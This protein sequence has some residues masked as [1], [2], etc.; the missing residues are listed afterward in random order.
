MPRRHEQIDRIEL[1]AKRCARV[2]EDSVG[3]RV[4]LIATGRARERTAASELVEGALNP[5][6]V[7]NVPRPIA[8]FHDVVEAGLIIRETG[9]KLAYRE[10]T[11]PLKLRIF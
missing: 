8:N 4:H 5:A 3:R 9:E 10:P 11:K 2:V 7:A 1:H 6:S